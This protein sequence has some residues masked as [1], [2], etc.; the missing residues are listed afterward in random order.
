MS[1]RDRRLL[2]G[3][4]RPADADSDSGNFVYRVVEPRKEIHVEKSRF[5]EA[6]I[7][8]IL[9]RLDARVPSTELGWR[10]TIHANTTR[11]LRDRYDRT[12][13]SAA[14]LCRLEEDPTLSRTRLSQ[15]REKRDP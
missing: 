13:T 14:R 3:I 4:S 15:R 5:T 8:S 2:S 12:E 10:H 1:A 9:E 6:Q 7:V 11:L